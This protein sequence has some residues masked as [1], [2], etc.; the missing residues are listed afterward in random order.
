M[1]KKQPERVFVDA[2]FTP[3]YQ[4]SQGFIEEVGAG[5]FVCVGV[6]GKKGGRVWFQVRELVP[7]QG[8]LFAAGPAHD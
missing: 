6:E 3:R 1:S 7:A 5:G 2:A 4:G 8:E